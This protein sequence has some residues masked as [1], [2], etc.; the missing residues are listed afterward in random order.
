MTVAKKYELVATDTINV[1]GRTLYRIRALVAIAALGVLAGDTGGYVESEANLSQVYGDA[2]VYGD[3][4]VYGDA[5]VYGD[6]QVS[7]D[8]WVYGDAR[9]YGNAQVYGN[10]WV[11]GDA[12]VS[13][14][15]IQG[16]RWPVTIADAQMVIGCQSHDLTRWEKFSDR[17][18]AAMDSDAL[19][20]WADHKALI[21]GLAK[22][23]GRPL[24]SVKA[25]RDTP[26]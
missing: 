5:R 13:P 7:G 8:A 24:A 18:I 23:N 20:F 17:T 10:A 3:A 6:A 11:Y 25:T 15:H 9:V 21:L 22:A 2:W 26:A 19:A 4:Q 16:L 12:R 1:G 14:I